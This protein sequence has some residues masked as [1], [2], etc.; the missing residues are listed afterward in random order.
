MFGANGSAKMLVPH[1][2]DE[3]LKIAKPNKYYKAS[4]K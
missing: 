2:A 3:V 1:L 4:V